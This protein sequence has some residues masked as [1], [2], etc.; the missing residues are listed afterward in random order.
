M[1]RDYDRDRDRWPRY[2]EDDERRYARDDARE[3]RAWRAA[4][5]RG[6]R[7]FTGRTEDYGWG[8]RER[9]RGGYM[10]TAYEPY[11]GR[12]DYAYGEERGERYGQPYRAYGSEYGRGY[13]AEGYREPWRGGWGREG[14]RY[15]PIYG[16][17]TWRVTET[18]QAGPYA[19]RGPR[20]Y[21]RSDDRIRD[22]VC[23]RLTW[24]G[25]VDASDIEVRVD[26]GEVTLSG[27]VDDRMQKRMAEDVA[28]MVPGVRDVHNEL[29]VRQGAAPEW[30][31]E[32]RGTA[33]MPTGAAAGTM[34]GTTGTATGTTGTMG[35]TTQ[36]ATG[37][38]YRNRIAA[39]MDVVG[40]NGDTVGTVK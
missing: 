4:P 38:E 11:R 17:E 26:N 25:Q 30:R 31:Q 20:G 33:G 21:Q 15:G 6:D 19:G 13:G 22:D 37:T 32:Y 12:P 2:D 5:G 14:T 27:T 3:Q 29:R 34:T 39:G 40:A 9:W 7:D 35:A 10:G 28:E 23:E 8:G 24:N 18:W 36:A 1:D 16:T